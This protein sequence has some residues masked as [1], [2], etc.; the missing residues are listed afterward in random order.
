[1][2][3]K[4]KRPTPNYLRFHGAALTP[5]SKGHTHTALLPLHGASLLPHCLH[6]SCCSWANYRSLDQS[7]AEGSS[8]EPAVK[9]TAGSQTSCQ[10]PALA[11]SGATP[12]PELAAPPPLSSDP[13][14]LTCKFW[15]PKCFSALG[16]LK[17]SE[18]FSLLD[19][20]LPTAA[21]CKIHH[22][23]ITLSLQCSW[24]SW[25]A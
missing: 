25:K 16:E 15:L 3:N 7:Y 2:E 22:R 12:F 24:I 14:V 18:H 23:P 20:F 17:T 1:M 6:E 13:Q 5:F 19:V 21:I 10:H 9:T 8:T 4:I 11:C